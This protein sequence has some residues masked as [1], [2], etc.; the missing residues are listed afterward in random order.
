MSNL[1]APEMHPSQFADKNSQISNNIK[2]ERTLVN[3][4][5][6]RS[7]KLAVSDLTKL[8]SPGSY[9]LTLEDI[10][11]KGSN[12]NSMF[13][14]LYGETLLT[15]LFFSQE[16]VDNIQKLLRML[17]YKEMGKIIDNQSPTDLLIVMRSMFL[18]YS[19]HPE[20]IEPEMTE[21]KKNK[22]LV[23]YQNEV[24]RL[25]E[26]V[27]NYTVPQICSQLQQYLQYLEDASSPVRP[28]DKPVSTNVAG[29]KTYRS[30]TSVLTGS[31]L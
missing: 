24:A 12:T 23:Q 16:N 28:M 30:I 10:K 5:D 18:S 20:L 11:T 15:Y 31:N 4:T 17:V 21:E 14:N 22:L 19:N 8:K 29:T 7:L 27:V 25:N 9:S 13:K 1:K 26:L 3:L 2:G 6:E